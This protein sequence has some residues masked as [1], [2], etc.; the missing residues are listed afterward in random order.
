MTDDTLDSTATPS[1]TGPTRLER[2]IAQAD[3]VETEASKPKQGKLSI[4]FH[5]S[6]YHD[7]PPYSSTATYAGGTYWNTGLYLN[8]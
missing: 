3:A 6:H 1:P 5:G 7:T 4:H 2:P 8:T